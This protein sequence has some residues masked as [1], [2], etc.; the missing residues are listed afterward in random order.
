MNYVINNENSI[1]AI[2][3]VNPDRY[4]NLVVFCFILLNNS[5]TNDEYRKIEAKMIMEFE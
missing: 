4:Y 5:D 2:L 1:I 3:T